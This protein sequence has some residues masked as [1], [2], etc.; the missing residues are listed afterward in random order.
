M[1]HKTREAWLGAAV[2]L[3]R[4]VFEDA[5]LAVPPKL[6]AS[7]GWPGGGSINT[8][9]GECWDTK[10]SKDKT[11]EVFISPSLDRPAGKQGVL[12]ILVHEIV[13]ATVGV[14]QKHGKEFRRAATIVGLEGR[15]TST[16]AGPALQSTLAD[17]AG[18]LG[19]YPH[20]ALTPRK[21]EKKSK[22]SCRLLKA[23]CPQCGYVVR[24]TRKWLDDAGAP[25]CPTCEV[26]FAE[27]K[28]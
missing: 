5:G 13:H 20:A 3:L 6:R 17:I 28:K 18:E 15:M 4:P 10:C 27:E 19:P 12:A 1:T 8:R 26:P 2:G 11:A 21:R 22:S 24:V 23:A 16:T 25:I 9:I 7:C 14:D